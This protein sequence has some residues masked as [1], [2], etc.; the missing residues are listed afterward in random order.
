MAGG[1]LLEIGLLST[2]VQKTFDVG[3]A[4]LNTDKHNETSD[5]NNRNIGPQ[6]HNTYVIF[7]S[8]THSP[9]KTEEFEAF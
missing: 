1:V 2:N 4:S 5:K 7:P 6:I 9:T 3:G 8:L